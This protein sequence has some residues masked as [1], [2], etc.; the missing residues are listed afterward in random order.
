MVL[1]KLRTKLKEYKLARKV[2]FSAFRR[3]E[4]EILLFRYRLLGK[5]QGKTIVHFFHIR[6]TGGTSIKFAL[7]NINRPY[8]NDK[9][10]IF[11]H[12]HSFGLKDTFAGE[13][14]F[15]FIRD[16]IDRFVSGFYSRKRKGMPRI[17]IEWSS[18]EKKAFEAFNTPNELAISLSEKDENIRKKAVKAM[19][20]INHVRSSYWD[21]FKNEELFLSRTQDVIFVGVQKKLNEEFFR[22]KEILNLPGNLELPKDK[23]NKHENPEYFDKHLDSNAIK[24]LEKWYATDFQFL[25][26]LKENKLL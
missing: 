25:Q 22:L 17:Y 2:F 8:I 16:P 1:S 21:W 6:K 24:N 23:V 26:L 18:N 3:Y 14:F 4:K 7:K 9:Y 5:I 20:S 11:S 19:K 12:S 10:I 13:K 15:F